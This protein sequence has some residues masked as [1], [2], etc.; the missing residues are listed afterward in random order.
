MLNDL[1]Y[2]DCLEAARRIRQG[3]LSATEYIQ[4]LLERIATHDATLDTFVHLSD[5]QAKLTARECDLRLR[6][7][8]D[9]GPLHGVPFALKDIIDAKGIATTAHSKILK[10][11]IAKR[12]AQVTRALKRAGAIL[13]GKLAT[14]EFACGG[15]CF[16]LPWPPARNPWNRKLFP[17]GS[18][19]GPAAAV[20]AGFVPVA[21]G[22]DSAGSI[23]GPAALCGIVGM[24]PTYG[25]VSRCGVF[26]LA[27]T[28]DTVGPM[29]RTVAE[30]AAVLNV[31]A[32]CDSQAP[33]Y[34][35]SDFT[36]RL[37]HG[38]RGLKVMVIRHFYESDAAAHPELILAMD[39]A[40]DTLSG[41][42]AEISDCTVRELSEYTRCNGTIMVSEAYAR[43]KTWLSAR[44]SDYGNI[45]RQRLM[46]GRTIGTDDYARAKRL[47]A[48]I[49]LDLRRIL[50]TSDVIVT[51]SS[52]DPPYPI[53]DG[54]ALECSHVRQAFG[55]FSLT[56]QP[57]IAVP[58]GFTKSGL[59]LSMQIAGK[60]FDE[61]TVY[62]VAN[63]YESATPWKS[64]RPIL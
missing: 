20:A 17:G 29:T 18:S 57:A 28:L 7:G 39:K 23:R 15:P 12:D 8:K 40:I 36:A 22:S 54:I 1:I 55:L 37:D 42:G 26:P 51:A 24:K 58:C 4:V 41:L 46:V 6:D 11:N 10:D 33:A 27:S 52:F 47:R 56:G 59:P 25:R 50:E 30:N 60:D 43:H 53:D 64:C 9:V 38:I 32:A 16:D 63:A 3:E 35:T 19:S 21:I 31:I 45:T 13:M 2:M 61:A 48:E 14:H 62:Q 44:P 34:P 5:E 49:T